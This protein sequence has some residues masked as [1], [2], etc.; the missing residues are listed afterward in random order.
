MTTEEQSNIEV[1]KAGYAAFARGDIAGV[2]AMLDE[3]V[4]WSMP[5]GPALPSSGIKK[6]VEGVLRFFTVVNETWA[7]EAFEPREYIASGDRVCASGY[8]RVRARKTGRVAESE[9]VMMWRVRNGKCV[10]LQEYTDTAVLGAALVGSTAG[11]V[12]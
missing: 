12:G 11:A 7:F 10:Q 1:A 2:I 8:Y 5:G 9:W 6:G 3:N 4:E